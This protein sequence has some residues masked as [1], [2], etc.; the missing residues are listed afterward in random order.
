[1]LHLY[2]QLYSEI[3]AL[4]RHLSHLSLPAD[5]IPFELE[6]MRA[7]A[8]AYRPVEGVIGKDYLGAVEELGVLVATCRREARR[9]LGRSVLKEG[10]DAKRAMWRDRAM[11]VGVVL[12]GVLIEIKVGW[13]RFQADNRIT[14]PP[15][16][17][18]RPWSINLLRPRFCSSCC[19]ST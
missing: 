12:A 14:P 9:G 17:C 7:Q 3:T 5:S 4:F 18:W 11:R 1:M 8:R 13:S 16:P 10:T 6:V 19:P 2:V 15:L